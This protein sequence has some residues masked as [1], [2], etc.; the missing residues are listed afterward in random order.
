MRADLHLHSLCS[1]GAYPPAEV[2]RLAAEA[3]VELFSLTDHDNMAGCREAAEAARALGLHFV[4]GIE[5]SAYIGPTKVHM[6]GYGCAENAAYFRYLEACREGARRRAE[7]ILEKANR[8][9]SL[10]VTMDEVEVFHTRKEAPIH[11]MHVVNAFAK[12]LSS[13]M[14]ALF[15]AIFVPGAPAFSDLCRPSPID[16]VHLI[17]AMGGLAVI[18]HPAQILVLPEDVSA[19]FRH[20]DREAREEAKR[21]YAGARNALMERLIEEGADG[22]ECVH[23][24]HTAEETEEFRAF[25]KAH[26][27]FVTGGSDFHSANSSRSV[28]SPV[29]DASEIAELLLSL[30]GSV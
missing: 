17:H 19:R 20:F 28:G 13:D 30:K 2:A 27:L 15:G 5:I 7:D 23:S 3:G 26:G 1:D 22:I 16:A 4:R 8:A 18:A 9:L 21:T 25:A 14:G 24:T 10:D 29:F 6:L 11:L 12:R